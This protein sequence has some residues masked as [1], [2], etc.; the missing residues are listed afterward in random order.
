MALLNEEINYKVERTKNGTPIAYI[1]PKTSENVYNFKDIIKKYGGK[2]DSFAKRWYWWLST[3]KAK[4]QQILNNQVNPAIDELTKIETPTGNR[5]D[6]SDVKAQV[7][8]M[9]E[10]LDAILATPVAKTE[11]G[12]AMDANSVKN[13]VESF[14]EK[15]VNIT[16]SEEFKML[17]GPIIKFKQ[18]QGHQYSFHNIILIY[19]QDPKATMVKSKTRWKKVN[20]V[21]KDGAPIIWI[22]TPIN[23]IQYTPEQKEK[24]TKDFLMELG[25]ETVDDLTPGQKEKLS[26]K[27]SGY[28]PRDYELKP[29]YDH[30]FTEPITGKEDL[31]P[32]ANIDNIEWFD[33]KSPSSEKTVSL[34]DAA[35]ASIQESGIEVKFV[36]DLGGARGVSTSGKIEVLKDTPKNIGDFNTL[37]HEFSHE[38]LHQSF[39]KVR[40][41]TKYGSFFVGTQQGRAMVEQQAE[42]SA[43]II[44]QY[45]GYEMPTS[46][47]YM[48]C[49]GMDE[50]SAA[51]VFDTVANTSSHIIELINKNMNMNRTNLQEGIESGN[52]ISGEDIANMVGLGK[53]YR[54]SKQMDNQTTIG[55][56]GSDIEEMVTEAVKRIL[57]ERT[58][59]EKGLSDDEVTR[60]RTLNFADSVEPEYE[61][62]IYN[63]KQQN[64]FDNMNSRRKMHHKMT[65]KH[66]SLNESFD[67]SNYTHFAVNKKT[68]LIVNGWDYSDYDNSELRAYADDYFW[69]DMRDYEFNPKEYRILSRKGCLKL[70]INPDD[71][72]NCWSNRGEIP[73]AQERM[74]K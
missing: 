22:N 6:S 50:K 1:D 44:C 65:Q 29:A 62:S 70:G 15:L 40:N 27:L 67:E 7:A 5:R 43:W 47:N 74:S 69:D 68:N 54:K 36:N 39:L 9:V 58:K 35:I 72:D 20:R 34:Y 23:M 3:D 45:F 61:D 71:M 51:R 17:L 30:R 46:I 73:C 16:S 53:L 56:N 24:I 38:L 4:T 52:I 13:K 28:K 41:N 55:I 37:V 33:D 60:K 14:K 63:D 2:W 11:E 32:N 59:S 26:V 21:V 49:W 31:A 18:A 10:A 57:K 64:H 66:E 12:N 42:L 48:G 8:K 25:V 19:L